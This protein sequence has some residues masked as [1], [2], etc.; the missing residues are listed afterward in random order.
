MKEIKELDVVELLKPLHSEGLRAG[1][2]GTVVMVFT[3]PVVAYEVEF[4]NKDG[5][6]RAQVTLQPDQVRRLEGKTK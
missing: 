1:E 2:I 6:T 3:S 4:V 5:S